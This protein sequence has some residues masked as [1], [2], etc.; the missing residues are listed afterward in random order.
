[1]LHWTGVILAWHA[2]FADAV[3]RVGSY[4]HC[5]VQTDDAMELMAGENRTVK[6]GIEAR[7]VFRAQVG[8]F[9][10]VLVEDTK[11]ISLLESFG[12]LSIDFTHIL[13]VILLFL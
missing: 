5:I 7:K 4:V 6:I 11:T 3:L 2:L 13:F 8:P 1:M 12:D 9:L 10:I